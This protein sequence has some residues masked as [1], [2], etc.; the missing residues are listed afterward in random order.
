MVH[1]NLPTLKWFLC[2]GIWACSSSP[3]PATQ[4]ASS[5][6]DIASM[7]QAQCDWE[8]RCGSVVTQCKESC[9]AKMGQN[10]VFRSE[11]VHA[12]GTCYGSLA[13][14]N[15]DDSCTTAAL[16]AV[17]ASL[18]DTGYQACIARH[19]AC[20]SDGTSD[21]SDDRCFTRFMFIA[22]AVAAVDRCLSQPCEQIG[23]CIDGVMGR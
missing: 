1:F 21:F 20:A 19:E 3:A 13:C 6:A 11:A 12:I 23:A 9:A 22:S 7:C 8:Q 15:G 17:N 14:G 18:N 5:A 10:G 16:T 2:V 4:S